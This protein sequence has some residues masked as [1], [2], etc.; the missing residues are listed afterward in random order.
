MRAM[1]QLDDF[2]D[3]Q[4]GEVAA[5]KDHGAV[6]RLVDAGDQVE[7][8]GLARAVGADEAAELVLR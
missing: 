8:G 7:D 3:A 6:G 1:P 5:A 2:V 4:S